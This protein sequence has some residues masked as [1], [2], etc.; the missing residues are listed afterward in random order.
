MNSFESTRNRATEYLDSLRST[1]PDFEDAFFGSLHES[2]AVSKRALRGS[3]FSAV[4]NAQRHSV[5]EE[6]RLV[7]LLTDRLSS[8]RHHIALTGNGRRATYAHFPRPR[9]TNVLLG[10]GQDEPDS[11]LREIDRGIY[12]SDIGHAW[13]DPG[14]QPYRWRFRVPD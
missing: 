1:D 10:A 4:L 14:S 8:R 9:M 7:G 12:V 5:I 6:G 13:Y 3:R 11:L 2:V